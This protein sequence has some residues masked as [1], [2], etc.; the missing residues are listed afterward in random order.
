MTWDGT[1]EKFADI[2]V[3]KMASW[4]SAIPFSDWPQQHQV[5]GQLRPAMVTERDWHKFGIMAAP[6]MV[7]LPLGSLATV[8]NYMLSVVMPGHGITQ[9]KDTLGDDWIC[10]VHVPLVTNSAVKFIIEGKGYEMD[11]GC[12]YRVN[13]SREH[14]VMNDGVTPRIHF[15]FDCYES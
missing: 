2:D 14:S 12:A 11:V 6:V 13:V 3:A 15:M 7:Q 9:H 10:R 4:I 5:D 8:S 1:C